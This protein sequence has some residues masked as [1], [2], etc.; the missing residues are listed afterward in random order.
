MRRTIEELNKLLDSH[1]FSSN[2]FPS[3]SIAKLKCLLLSSIN[4]LTSESE[5][6]K[7]SQT[8]LKLISQLQGALS[9]LSLPSSLSSKEGN[10]MESSESYREAES[11]ELIEKL[12]SFQQRLWAPVPSSER[13]W[14]DSWSESDLQFLLEETGIARPKSQV[15]IIQRMFK[16]DGE[17]KIL[18]EMIKDI[19]DS[20]A[21]A[22]ALSLSLSL[23]SSSSNRYTETIAKVKKYLPELNQEETARLMFGL[24]MSLKRL[25]MVRVPRWWIDNQ[26]KNPEEERN[27]MALHGGCGSIVAWIQRKLSDKLHALAEYT[28]KKIVEENDLYS[29]VQFTYFVQ[30]TINT[31]EFHE[32]D[33]ASL[34]LIQKTAE[35]EKRQFFDELLSRVQ[36]ESLD[37]PKR[38][39]SL[40]DIQED[41][42]VVYFDRISR[43]LQ[44][45]S[46]AIDYRFLISK[47]FFCALKEEERAIIDIG[48][49]YSI[50][51]KVAKEIILLSQEPTQQFNAVHRIRIGLPP[52]SDC[53]WS[54]I[55]SW[56]I[57]SFRKEEELSAF[58]TKRSCMKLKQLCLTSLHIQPLPFHFRFLPR[59]SLLIFVEGSFSA[60]L[61]S[62]STAFS[63]HFNQL[64]FEFADITQKSLVKLSVHLESVASILCKLTISSKRV[65]DFP[66]SI[67]ML[68]QM[69]QLS[70][71][72]NKIKSIPPRIATLQRLQNLNLSGNLIT[73]IPPEIKSLHKL[74]E[75]NLSNNN[76]QELP[77]EMG[78]LS[79][80]LYLNLAKNQLE[81]IPPFLG[82]L[83]LLTYLNL[84]TNAIC[85]VCP[86]I[87]RLSRLQY[88]NLS[89][90][91][92][93]MLPLELKNLTSLHT[94]DISANPK[95]DPKTRSLFS[96]TAT[97]FI[98]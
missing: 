70:L 56:A 26:L 67:G 63:Q 46:F 89:N 10:S 51:K 43:I 78:D 52:A 80:L 57:C 71:S 64:S 40:E 36:I 86:E 61:P 79:N 88:L 76:I 93:K 58:L 38:S 62:L 69:K 18:K 60:L 4:L 55:K 50:T 41:Q 20:L 45:L 87:E 72:L 39:L 34:V 59:L 77:P 75:L 13:D 25:K 91:Q 33:D 22:L 81:L 24:E 48:Q 27:L 68:Q 12:F 94:F 15:H 90:N 37:D 73:T 29:G 42:T 23:P 32:F 2:C 65:T 31:M 85:L 82:S 54:E 28:L 96:V 74:Q 95:L 83:K 9:A 98:C 92:I 1:D 44:K 47:R 49:Y 66:V 11:H 30:Y 7:A 3:S 5:K 35:D 8:R 53:L 6:E 97:T 14:I 21:K 17:G 84:S 19:R 16:E